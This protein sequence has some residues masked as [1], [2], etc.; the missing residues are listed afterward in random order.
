[1]LVPQTIR[2]AIC[3]VLAS[4]GI[5]IPINI[6]TTGKRTT[7]KAIPAIAGPTPFDWPALLEIF[8]R[9]TM[10]KIIAGIA[11]IKQ[12]K[13]LRIASTSEA[14]A[15]PLVL[16]GLIGCC[17][18][19]GVRTAL[20][21]LHSWAASG[22]CVPHF[23]QYIYGLLSNW[24]LDTLYLRKPFS[25]HYSLLGRNFQDIFENWFLT[26]WQLFLFDCLLRPAY[27]SFL[28]AELDDVSSQRG[29]VL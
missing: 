20:H 12:V 4:A 25:Y 27:V 7:G 28:V 21:E 6:A 17:V 3:L 22:F 24:Y 29:G 11:E 9:A 18:A 16:G 2:K 26:C 15:S 5:K 8:T 23:G 14:M 19:G 13:G 10:P 1:M